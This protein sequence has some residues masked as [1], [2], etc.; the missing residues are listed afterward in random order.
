[1]RHIAAFLLVAS[2]AAPAAAQ[3]RIIAQANGWSAFGG[4]TEGGVPTCGLETRDPNTGR[5]F[6]L[7]HLVGQ[8]G[9]ILRLSRPG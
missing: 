8:D 3:T 6:L 5:H 9:P 7:Q 4:T 1:M 2:V